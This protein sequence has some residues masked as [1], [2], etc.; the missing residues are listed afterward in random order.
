[1][2][3][4][5]PF[6][7]S[8]Q[9][10]AQLA[11][12][13]NVQVS[14][15]PTFSS[16]PLLYYPHNTYTTYNYPNGISP[17]SQPNYT[18][19]PN[20]PLNQLNYEYGVNQPITPINY[21]C[22]PEYSLNE[23]NSTNRPPLLPLSEP[24]RTNGLPLSL[25]HSIN[26]SSSFD[27]F[28]HR[29]I[30]ETLKLSA[31]SG[32]V[33]WTC[34]CCFYTDNAIHINLCK[35]CKSPRFPSAIPNKD[36]QTP[37]TSST[38]PPKS[39]P[40]IL[41]ICKLSLEDSQ[42]VKPKRRNFWKCQ[43][44][45]LHNLLTVSVCDACLNSR[46]DATN[47][48]S[49]LNKNSNEKKGLCKDMKLV[50]VD[51]SSESCGLPSFNNV[52]PW[53]CSVCTFENRKTTVICDMCKT[54]CNSLYDKP[55]QETKCLSEEELIELEWNYI[56]SNCKLEKRLFVDE[57]FPAARSSLYYFSDQHQEDNTKW[58]RL[59]N[60]E[61][62]GVDRN[63]SWTLF[64]ELLE[65]PDVIQG[66]LGNCWFMSALIVLIER[67]NLI[68]SL[69]ITQK[70]CPQGVYQ[71]RLC[72]DGVWTTI[73]IDDFV[74][75]DEDGCLLFAYATRKQLW[76]PL[77]E[78]AAAK[79]F[80][81]YEALNNGSVIEAL[82]LLTGAPCEDLH[83]HKGDC[84]DDLVWSSL[85]V[86]RKA[87]FVMV[88][89]CNPPC[90]N[91][92]KADI[93]KRGLRSE[94]LYSILDVCEIEGLR[95]LQLRDPMDIDNWNGDWSNYSHLWTP[96][97]QERLLP[98]GPQHGTFWMT[99][100]DFTKFFYSVG[101][102]KIRNGWNEMIFPGTFPSFEKQNVSC[103]SFIIF[104]P[105]EVDFVLYQENQRKIEPSQ[106]YYMDLSLILFKKTIDST[107]RY[108]FLGFSQRLLQ[109][110]ISY[111]RKLE[112]GE[113][114][115][116]PISFNHWHVENITNLGYQLA[117]HSST[118]IF[119]EMEDSCSLTLRDVIISLTRTCGQIRHLLPG[120]KIYFLK[121][122]F[123]G[124]IILLEN[125]YDDKWVQIKCTDDQN[126]HN[127]VCSRGELLRTADSIPPLH[128][129]IIAIYTQ[130]KYENE[131]SAVHQL[132]YR[133]SFSPGLGNWGEQTNSSHIPKIDA[134]DVL[135]HTFLLKEYRLLT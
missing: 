39:N 31:N 49:S 48:N 71:I 131:F 47:N 125:H 30:L 51:E 55:S 128:G 17:L 120:L 73:L 15:C 133:V 74:P 114:I 102:C 135:H 126:C 95:L 81:C 60:V 96:Y 45:T 110:Y 21:S 84:D 68:R 67:E 69:F 87:F 88:S 58:I 27:P 117:I 134:D 20:Q 86:A 28:Q 90:M 36:N 119:A 93:E 105:T 50:N 76:I 118:K 70:L 38:T 56:V 124:S 111:W 32:H 85:V 23:F 113:Y 29:Q 122:G 2:Q 6:Y 92:E 16:S 52:I 40:N 107:P 19:V 24:Q 78:K 5:V 61:V 35:A 42:P 91:L 34:R 75:C 116:V 106:R 9:D 41:K 22:K 99:F 46:E 100:E 26:S 80:G 65:P 4:N 121:R 127:V 115:I 112:P 77:I 79:L 104:E 44:C 72:K 98:N 103:V 1:M 63:L 53:K 94:H 54:I 10:P 130:L 123:C 109:G 8:T 13:N 101:V 12:I 33:N 129:Q 82:N 57:T 37:S 59:R 89:C 132:D 18:D 14:S 7:N 97:L 11:A 108:K 43:K 3:H 25:P 64:R 66:E 62:D 83:L